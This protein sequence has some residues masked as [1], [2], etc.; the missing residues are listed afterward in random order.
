[1]DPIFLNFY[2]FGSILIVLYFFYAA[3]FFLTIKERSQAAFH[4]G[5]CSLTTVFLNL[6][7]LWGFISFEENTIYHRIVAIAGPLMSF[8]QLVGFFI[9]FPE[10]RKKGILPGRILYWSLY[11]GVALV[12]GYYTLICWNAPRTFV[13][14]SH[15]WDY[16]VPQ[17]YVYQVYIILFYELCYLVVGV[18]RAVIEKGKERRSVVYILLSYV[19][20]TVGPGILNAM[21]RIGAVSRATYHQV[22]NLG[23]VTGMFLIMVVYVN[24]TKERTTILNRIV[25]VSL[26]TFFVCYQ[27]VGYSILNGY[28]KSYDELKIRDS[29]IAVTEGKNPEGLAYIVSYEPE[30]NEFRQERGEKDPRFRKEDELEVR[31]F[32]EK[33]RICNLGNL[34]AE[35]RMEKTEP[36]LKSAPSEFKAYAAGIRAFLKS[37]KGQRVDDPEMS[38]YFGEIY[39]KLNII[40]NK[41]NRLPD[42]TNSK[43]IGNLLNSTVPGL[44]ET[45]SYVRNEALDAV[46]S[47][48]S[49][50]HISKIILN[51][52]APIHEVGERIYRGTRI[53]DSSDPKPALYISYYYV[54]NS[55]D[56]IY[57]VGYEY[58]NYR[59]YQ[60]SPSFVLIVTMTLTFLVIVVGFRFFFQ[61]AIVVPVDE[62]LVGLKEVNSG[63][64]DYR[65]TPR[66]EDEI[67]FI[68]RSF[69]KMTRSIQAARKRLQQYADELEEKVRER[70]GEL[71]RTLNAVNELKQQQDGDYFLTSL[72]I[73][74]LGANKAHSDNVRVDFLLEQKKKFSF[75]RFNDEIGGDMNIS[76]RILLRNQWYTIFLNADAMGK[77]MQGAGGALV[78]GAVFES[79]IER[80]RIEDSMKEQ[81]PERWLKNS[82]LELHKVFE[83][84]EG[85]MLVSSV[86]GLVEEDSGS[87]YYINA[88]H[89]WTCLYRDGKADFLEK[90]MAFRKLGTTGMEGKISVRTFQLEPGDVVI[91]GSDGRDDILIGTD[92]DGSRIINDDENLFLK[93]VEEGGGELNRIYDSILSRGSLTDDLSLVRISFKEESV[94]QRIHQ[95][96]KI[97]ELLGKARTKV[98]EKN[99]SEALAYLE[100][101]DSLDSKLPEVKK[102]VVKYCIRLKEYAK[103]AK[104]AE[105]YLN[106]RPVDKEILFVAS[107]A[108]RRAHQFHKAQDFGERLLIRDP[109]HVRNLVNLSRICIA[110][111]NFERARMLVGEAIR[112]DPENR[113]LLK[114]KEALDSQKEEK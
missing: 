40:R 93:I 86:I 72:L 43:A 91:A 26:A 105:E 39:G 101:A 54:P 68:A 77:S 111:R 4:L 29:S 41:Y 76:N 30:E 55:G 57:E 36:I 58:K 12:T 59:M 71:E 97:R 81:S 80:T 38:D 8:T 69:N 88:E 73:K 79:I 37:K 85:S 42:G 113:I 96:E 32:R 94:P 14:G 64:L 52:L 20:I 2:S 95:R 5:I 60:H 47:E 18:W 83:S 82:F 66:V 15:Y 75:R 104:F 107:F 33:R 6:G 49:S 109:L 99:F 70:T 31:F 90:D 50:E 112:L 27:L 78:L 102:A 103:A 9:N 51:S 17:F 62:V 92:T 61:N 10:P 46:K 89:P 74:P 7:Y 67:G 22:F 1:M 24:A 100:E 16:E 114:I 106:I 19:V 63:N 45:L 98:K 3:Y 44:S 21:S 84:F 65:L 23:F 11:A 56:K 35:A 53:Y 108:A 110:L 87:L 25:G 13:A 34:S 28:E 48:K